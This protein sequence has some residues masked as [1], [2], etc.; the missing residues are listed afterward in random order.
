MTIE[1]L[2]LLIPI[3]AITMGCSIPLLAIFMEHRKRKE[4]FTLHH[5]ERM[6]A[7]EKGIELPPWPEG[8]FKEEGRKDKTKSPHS[9][10]GWGLFWLL[11][12]VALLV[13]LYL[14]EKGASALYALIPIAIGLH[15]L[16]YYYVIGRKEAAATEAERKAK[17][18]EIGRGSLL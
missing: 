5:Q 4:M 12:G 17:A 16:I 18:A 1:I 11:G 8:F 9:D 13:A 6:A 10:F 14:N 15:Y 2:R 3:I 7:I